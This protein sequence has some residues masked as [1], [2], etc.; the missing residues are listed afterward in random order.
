MCRFGLVP[1]DLLGTIDSGSKL[2]I[3]QNL[4]C[5]FDGKTRPHHSGFFNFYAWGMVHL[6]GNMW[7]LW[8]FGDNVE[9]AMGPLRFILFYLLRGWSPRPLKSRPTR[10]VLFQWWALLVPLGSYG[11]VRSPLPSSSSSNAS[12]SWFLH[13]DALNSRVFHSCLVVC[14]PARLR[15]AYA[16]TTRR[17]RRLLGAHRWLSRRHLARHTFSSA[18][19]TNHRRNLGERGAT[20]P[21]LRCRC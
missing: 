20:L 6:I 2:R 19:V 13:H 21:N 9:D 8:V 15:T 10:A 17:G 16:R 18:T 4:I 7:F 5:Q 11:R 14:C 12:V 3:A 1:G